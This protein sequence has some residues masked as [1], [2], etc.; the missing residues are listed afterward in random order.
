VTMCGVEVFRV[1]DGKITEV[2]NPPAGPGL[3]G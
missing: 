3:W 1:A 2:W